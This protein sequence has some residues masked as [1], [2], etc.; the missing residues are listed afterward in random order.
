MKKILFLFSFLF[1]LFSC[2]T[3]DSNVAE[4]TAKLESKFAYFTGSVISY[5]DTNKNTIKVSDDKLM[6]VFKEF[7]KE[8]KLNIEP[9]YHKIETIDGKE[10][11]RF[12][13]KGNYVSTVDLLETN[14]NQSKTTGKTVCTSVAC[15][16]GGGCIPNGDYCTVCTPPNVQPGSGLTG[17]CT[18]TTS[19]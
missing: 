7:V 5:E 14:T 4:A 3:E 16:S 1:I 15:A 19:N 12:Y 8:N 18:R 10:Y 6:Q 11:L 9:L 13:S 17:D 2:E